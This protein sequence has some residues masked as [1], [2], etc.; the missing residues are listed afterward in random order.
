ME[1][2]GSLQEQILGEAD[3]G[4]KQ[5]NEFSN[6]C[7]KRSMELQ[8]EIKTATSEV[9]DLKATIEKA[10]DDEAALDT[11]IEELSGTMSSSEA[12]LKAAT[13]IRTKEAGD[14]A[15]DQKDLIDTIGKMERAIRILEQQQKE[16]KAGSFV[17]EGT[18]KEEARRATA[19]LQAMSAIVDASGLASAD[20]EKLAS[21]LETENGDGDSDTEDDMESDLATYNAAKGSASVTA[22]LEGLLEKAQAQLEAARTKETQERF[23]FENFK[24]SLERKIAV[25]TKDMN[26]AK[27]SKAEAGQ[28]RAQAQGDLEVVQKDLAED[29]VA[30]ENLHQECMAKASD[31]EEVTK[32]RGEELKAVAEAKKILQEVSGQSSDEGASA[33]QRV[34][35]VQTK[36]KSSLLSPSQAALNFLRSLQKEEVAPSLVQLIHKV[37]SVMRDSA[38]TA[39][40]PFRKVKS[41]LQNMLDSL[42]KEMDEEASHKK[43]CDKE[44]KETKKSKSVKE[45]TEEKLQTKIDTQSSD[46]MSLKEQVAILQ[47]EL[48]AIVQ[49]QQEMDRLRQTEKAAFAKNKPEVEQG[50]AAV[51]K[52]M[53]VLRSYYS[54]DKEDGNS[55]GQGA[56][57]TI[58]G[59]LEVVEADFAKSLSSLDEEEQSAQSRYDKQTAENEKA[60]A[61]KQTDITFKTKQG[62]SLGKSVSELSADL[63]GVQNELDAVNEYFRQLQEECVAKAE[64]YEE[65][66]KRQEKLLQG[67]QDALQILQGR[68]TLLQESKRRF[69]GLSGSQQSMETEAADTG[70]EATTEE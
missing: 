64:P 21:L 30:L 56:G 24:A 10:A 68:A 13:A 60:K 61:I 1:L 37:E 34:S 25:T 44:M 27:K 32:A 38:V 40:D 14:F 50:Y 63:D 12:D 46:V 70:A 6:M 2:L 20:Q 11:D 66:R 57:T 15:E 18:R 54:Q 29:K 28:T 55:Y 9:D 7:E 65:R 16:A 8:F 58:I 49:T 22:T 26:D 51:K 45:A 62:K 67:L 39:A 41:M 4:H 48:L 47:K 3:V 17:Q 52:A 31:Y 33:L 35:F 36:S 19:F 59:M 23:A 5:Y 42:T 69:R 43:Y 53:Q